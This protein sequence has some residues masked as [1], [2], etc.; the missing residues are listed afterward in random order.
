M[1]LL[2]ALSSTC[3]TL[4]LLLCISAPLLPL[5]I[6]SFLY[7][8]MTIV[9]HHSAQEGPKRASSNFGQHSL[10]NQHDDV[11]CRVHFIRSLR[12]S[13][14]ADNAEHVP[15]RLYAG[16][17][18]E[19]MSVCY[20]IFLFLF[21]FSYFSISPIAVKENDDHYLHMHY[22]EDDRLYLVQR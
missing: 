13:P 14:I 2:A 5:F 19:G 22:C 6:I 18:Q 9:K 17:H 15:I 3:L 4:A 7:F 11:S 8:S 1:L 20:F 16:T 10:R 21:F 12:N